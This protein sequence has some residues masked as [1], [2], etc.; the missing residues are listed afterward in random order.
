MGGLVRTKCPLDP[1]PG[2]VRHGLCPA[3]APGAG[4]ALIGLAF[5]RSGMLPAGR[6]A[7]HRLWSLRGAPVPAIL[8]HPRP[9]ERFWICGGMFLWMCYAFQFV[10]LP[11]IPVPLEALGI[12]SFPLLAG[13]PGP[14][15]LPAAPGSVWVLLVLP[16]AHAAFSPLQLGRE[17]V[18]DCNGAQ[19]GKRQ[20]YPGGNCPRPVCSLLLPGPDGLQKGKMNP[21]GHKGKKGTLI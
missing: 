15:E 12:L 11:G 19:K 5:C 17:H 10:F 2:V 7:E 14:P 6:A 9:A 8:L 18:T 1:G 20:T 3:G 21:M 4:V 16:F 13:L